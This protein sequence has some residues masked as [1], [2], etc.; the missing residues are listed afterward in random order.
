M[1]SW[2]RAQRAL[3]DVVACDSFLEVGVVLDDLLKLL[4]L[5]AHGCGP[6]AAAV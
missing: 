1:L 3:T 2:T 5:A 4:D 6:P